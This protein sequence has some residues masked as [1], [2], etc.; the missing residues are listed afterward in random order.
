M[1]CQ[2]KSEIVISIVTS[3]NGKY[4]P[5]MGVH[6]ETMQ[7]VKLRSIVEELLRMLSSACRCKAPEFAKIAGGTAAVELHQTD[8]IL[9]AVIRSMGNSTRMTSG[10]EDHDRGSHWNK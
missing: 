6:S 3:G 1:T 10:T 8:E 9:Q 7:R 4:A 5:I 2:V